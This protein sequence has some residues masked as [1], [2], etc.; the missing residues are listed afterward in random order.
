MD[1]MLETIPLLPAIISV[2]FATAQCNRSVKYNAVFYRKN[3][4]W[5]RQ[6]IEF[7]PV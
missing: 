6:Y 3:K 5:W 4:V 7:C 1:I 2:G